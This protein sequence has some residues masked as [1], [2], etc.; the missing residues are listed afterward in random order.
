MLYL[1]I[2]MVG[3]ILGFLLAFYLVFPAVDSEE[4]IPSVEEILETKNT[5]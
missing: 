2:F 4:D 1:L 5:Y 3:L